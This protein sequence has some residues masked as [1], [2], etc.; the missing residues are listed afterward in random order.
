MR[1]AI[2]AVAFFVLMHGATV[3]AYEPSPEE[4]IFI[5]DRAFVV[6][7]LE[8]GAHAEAFPFLECMTKRGDTRAQSFLSRE[9]FGK[10]D[11]VE[12]WAWASL[13]KD[14]DPYST[15][16]F[17]DGIKDRMTE[18]QLE[19]AKAKSFTYTGSY[20]PTGTGWLCKATRTGSKVS[21]FC[22]RISG[23]P[24]SVSCVDLVTASHAQATE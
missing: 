19:R 18:E 24:H 10:N 13:V 21:W 12:A 1:T 11:L 22:S 23:R 15:N 7:L 5:K 9:Y 17:L 3:L 2:P 20:G 14:A 16:I 6:A 4:H 8:R